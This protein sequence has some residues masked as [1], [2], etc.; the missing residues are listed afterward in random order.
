VEDSE[1]FVEPFSGSAQ[2]ASS[3]A[4]EKI[5]PQ[6]SH[7]H[8]TISERDAKPEPKNMLKLR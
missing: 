2:R 5:N 4:S 8:L 1:E 3:I 6:K 7:R